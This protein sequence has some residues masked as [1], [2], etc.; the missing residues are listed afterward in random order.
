MSLHLVE[1][2]ISL[3][4]LNRWAGPR[5]FARGAFDEGLALHHLL[6][7]VFG[8]AA[9][10][11]FRMLVAPRAQAGTLYAYAARPAEAL[12]R[13]AAAVIGPSHA[14][15]VALD[16]LRSLP[17]PADGWRSGQRLGFDLRL[18]PVVR[19]ASA[20]AGT[21][22]AKGAEIDAFLAEAL[23][24][25]SARPREAVY[26]DWLA[27]RLAPAARLERETSRL[28]AFQRSAINRNG[29]ALDGPDAIIHGTLSV[30]DPAGFADLLARG[31]GRHRSYGY[32]MLLLRPPQRG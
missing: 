4:A 2:P 11:P 15:V 1:M 5:N 31:I 20:I 13:D 26:L 23:R 12:R 30:T 8:P 19:L 14:G 21:G 6:G 7:E 27:A 18:R 28:H 3:P 9:L 29:R 25:G 22:F 32:G 10:Q 16:G 24:V 17:R